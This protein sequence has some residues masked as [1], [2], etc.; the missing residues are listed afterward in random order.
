MSPSIGELIG[1]HLSRFVKYDDYNSYGAWRLYMRIRVAV[2]VNEALK[3]KAL[4]LRRRME[5]LFTCI[6]NMKN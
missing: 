5:V 4:L 2:R 3:K 1:S 6:S